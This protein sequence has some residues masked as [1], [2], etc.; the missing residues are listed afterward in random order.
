M[1]KSLTIFLPISEK[2]FLNTFNLLLQEVLEILAVFNEFQSILDLKR[3]IIEISH[4]LYSSIYR[5]TKIMGF[6]QVLYV[7]L[8]HVEY[9]MSRIVVALLHAV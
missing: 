8:L 4:Y 7:I 9:I 5:N 6:G 3:L 2:C 1:K